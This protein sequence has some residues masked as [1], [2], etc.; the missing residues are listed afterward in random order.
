M[1]LL[2][3]IQGHQLVILVDS[4]SSHTFLSQAVARNLSSVAK[5]PA[6][7]KVQVANGEVMFC[8]SQ[9]VSSDWVIGDCYFSSPLKVL[10]LQHF[11]MILGMDWLESFSP[12]K[13]H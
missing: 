10:P 12:M 9:V 11:D 4:G 7:I 6:P 8:D 3:S 5:L 1:K 13:I 2:G